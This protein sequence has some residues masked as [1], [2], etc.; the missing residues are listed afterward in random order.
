MFIITLTQTPSTA[1]TPGPFGT[2]GRAGT[3]IAIVASHIISV[4]PDAPTGTIIHTTGVKN[5]MICVSENYETVCKMLEAHEGVPE[6]DQGMP[7]SDVGFAA[8]DGIEPAAHDGPRSILLRR[9]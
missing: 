5:S 3:P 8:H 2:P 1:G 4:V 6:V 7:S 9:D